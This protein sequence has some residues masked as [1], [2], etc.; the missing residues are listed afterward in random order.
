MAHNLYGGYR[1]IP[2]STYEP[3]NWQQTITIKRT[4]WQ[5]LCSLSMNVFLK[6]QTNSQ[7]TYLAPKSVL[8]TLVQIPYWPEAHQR[9]YRLEL[10]LFFLARSPVDL[11][12]EFEATFSSVTYLERSTKDKNCELLTKGRRPAMCF[13]FYDKFFF[14]NSA[15]HCKTPILKSSF[16]RNSTVTAA[17]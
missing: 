3:C 6:K 13:L 10:S 9:K 17:L 15:W 16:T 8:K 5:H 4:S 7:G 12:E 11:A 14:Y 2:S 1:F